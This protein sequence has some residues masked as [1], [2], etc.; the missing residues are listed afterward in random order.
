MNKLNTL[1]FGALELSS[2]LN[3]LL[4]EQSN[5]RLQKSV[6]LLEGKNHMFRD[7]R[8]N[9]ARIKTRLTQLQVVDKNTDKDTSQASSSVSKSDQVKGDK[10]KGDKK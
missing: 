7:I 3:E 9:I 8:R 10:V 1:D 6:G 2:K 4:R 5:L